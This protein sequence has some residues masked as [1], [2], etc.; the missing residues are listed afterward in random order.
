MQIHEIIK[1][2]RLMKHYTQ[3][4]LANYLGVSTSAVNKWEN[5]ISYP[6]ITLLPVIAR[7]LDTDLNTLLSFKD[8]MTMEEIGIFLNFLSDKLDQEGLDA[9]YTCAMDKIKEFPTC[10]S[11]IFNVALFLDGAISMSYSNEYDFTI[12]EPLYK[13]LLQSN[14]LNIQNHSKRILIQRYIQKQEYKQAE[15]LLNSLS[16]LQPIDKKQLQIQ[17]YIAQGNLTKAVELEE[18][19]IYQ[20]V[21]KLQNML[22]TLMEIAI[23][24]GRN[25][26]ALTIANISS[27]SSKIFDLWEYNSYLNQFLYYVAIKDEDNSIRFLQ[28]LLKAIK[29]P[30]KPNQSV[31]YKNMI[32]KELDSQ[33]SKK[34]T[35]SLLKALQ[36]DNEVEFLK[37]NPLFQELLQNIQS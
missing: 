5:G 1:E 21:E 35:N 23:K 33:F 20:T 24:D 12:I 9:V 30:W 34:L 8:D 11:L 17:L 3:E 37:E 4:M 19:Q 36:N 2:K 26:D 14:D 15:E 27:A 18:V 13:R 7:V 6:D 32:T 16:D 31:L 10:D 25:E 22:H 29:Q 28:S